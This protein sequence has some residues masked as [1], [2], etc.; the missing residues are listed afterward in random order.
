MNPRPASQG[1]Q[2][3]GVVLTGADLVGFIGKA[4][5]V[6]LSYSHGAAPLSRNLL[7]MLSNFF[8]KF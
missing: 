2:E 8:A 1:Y 7:L 3:D 6:K 4:E 5:K